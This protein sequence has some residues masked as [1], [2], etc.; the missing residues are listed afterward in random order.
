MAS[1]GFKTPARVSAARGAPPTGPPATGFERRIKGV[2]GEGGKSMWASA[3]ERG[4]ASVAVAGCLPCVG[5]ARATR[6]CKLRRAHGANTARRTAA[7]SYKMDALG[8]E[9]RAFRM[10][11]GCDTTTPCAQLVDDGARKQ[12]PNKNACPLERAARLRTSAASLARCSLA[13][14]FR[15]TPFGR[16]RSFA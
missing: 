6:R 10:R 3:G 4:W 2:C 13:R 5:G 1:S 16:P 7:K 11:S 8:F 9:P 15:R 12:T 14:A